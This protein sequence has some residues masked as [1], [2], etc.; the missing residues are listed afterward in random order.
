MWNRVLAHMKHWGH[1]CAQA[2]HLH[3]IAW[4]RPPVAGLIPG[5]ARDT[6]RSK[7]ALIAENAPLRQQLIVLHRQV[8]RPHITRR[9]Q[10]CRSRRASA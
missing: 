8:K 3:F 7:A 4:T 9:A 2:F 6:T 10:K 1:H 5:T